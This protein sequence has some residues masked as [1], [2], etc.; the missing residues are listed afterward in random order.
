VSPLTSIVTV[1]VIFGDG[2]KTNLSIRI[3]ASARYTLALH[4]A[5]PGETAVATIVRSNQPIVAER[6]L[7]PGGGAR[8]GSTTPGIP[9]P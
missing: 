1:E 7:Y 2:T 9:L 4:E 5:F 6:S 3:P 8:G